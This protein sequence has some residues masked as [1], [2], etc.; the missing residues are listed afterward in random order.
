MLGDLCEC[1]GICGAC[2]ARVWR[3]YR[4]CSTVQGGMHKGAESS[5]M[6]RISCGVGVC[7]CE[8]VRKVCVE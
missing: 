7:E 4:A 2:V 8:F 3:V 1:V 6:M 5:L